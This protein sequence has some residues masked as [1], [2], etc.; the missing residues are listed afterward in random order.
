MEI[1]ISRNQSNNYTLEGLLPWSTY[2]VVVIA[3]NMFNGEELESEPSHA[4]VVQTMES[5]KCTYCRVRGLQLKEWDIF[6][7]I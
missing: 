6:I 5:S 1:R 3:Y 4:L 7:F 2:H